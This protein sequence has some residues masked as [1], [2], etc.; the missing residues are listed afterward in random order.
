[1]AD[2]LAEAFGIVNIHK[3]KGSGT[4]DPVVAHSECARSQSNDSGVVAD[5]DQ[6]IMDGGEQHPADVM[7][8]NSQKG[9]HHGKCKLSVITQ[10]PVRQ[11]VNGDICDFE[12]NG[13]I[14]DFKRTD[15]LCER[16][17]LNGH[18][19]F[20]EN[21]HDQSQETIHADLESESLPSSPKTPVATSRLNRQSSETEKC[22]QCKENN[23]DRLEQ[24]CNCSRTDNQ[25]QDASASGISN[26]IPQKLD[27]RSLNLSFGVQ[28]MGHQS[29]T[30]RYESHE[31]DEMPERR[32]HRS[33]RAAATAKQSWLL[34]LF[35]S[36]LFDMS[37]AITYLFNS[38][39]PGVQTYIGRFC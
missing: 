3:L 4:K 37:I 10:E 11:F 16:T 34:R 5:I 17:S 36:K 33:Q 38:K 14:P 2:Q 20:E 18:V 7:R 15:S 6:E 25:L 28:A 32:R 35:E 8:S 9:H 13:N 31:S 24:S 1:M 12:M 21:E 26:N 19:I 22:S 29:R 30:V 23:S 27:P 39:E